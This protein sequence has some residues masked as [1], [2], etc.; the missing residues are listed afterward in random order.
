MYPGPSV[1]APTG[2]RQPVWGVVEPCRDVSPSVGLRQRRPLR[3]GVHPG[4]GTGVGQPSESAHGAA[5]GLAHSRGAK[6]RFCRPGTSV[7]SAPRASHAKPLADGSLIFSMVVNT[8]SRYAS[9]L[10]KSE[11]LPG[12]QPPARMPRHP[13][14][15][16]SSLSYQACIRRLLAC[17]ISQINHLQR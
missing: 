13:A 4:H 8:T 2:R 6:S 15:S 7:P 10:P 11:S 9:R 16:I 1:A 17:A 12:I 5:P 3:D 14:C